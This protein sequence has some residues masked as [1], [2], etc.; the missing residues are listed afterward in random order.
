MNRLTIRGIEDEIFDKCK[1]LAK[2]YGK[3]LNQFILE[4][5]K[6]Q[7]DIKID[8]DT[9]EYHNLDHLFGIWSEEE[10]K[11]IERKIDSGRKID[12]EMWE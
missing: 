3:S 12:K 2:D 10:Y 7:T 8:T 5:L 6:E 9:I 11:A 4:L 1:E